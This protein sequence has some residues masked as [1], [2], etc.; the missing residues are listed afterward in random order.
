MKRLVQLAD[1]GLV[2]LS[3][4]QT[5][6]A[7]EEL[8]FEL[9]RLEPR[10]NWRN[11]NKALDCLLSG[12]LRAAFASFPGGAVDTSSPRP[13]DPAHESSRISEVPQNERSGMYCRWHPNRAK[14][15]EEHELKRRPR[16]PSDLDTVRP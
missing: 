16:E 14:W 4:A 5:G 3:S 10:R 13:C 8:C 12:P 6:S 9:C 2:G 7:A 11:S 15:L 1:N